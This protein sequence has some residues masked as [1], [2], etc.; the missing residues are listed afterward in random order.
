MTRLIAGS[1]AVAFVSWLWSVLFYVL[2]PI[3]YYTVSATR[4][5]LAA[6]AALLEHFPESGTYILPSRRSTPEVRATMRER[7]PVAT[8]YIKRDGAPMASP[9][10]VI[11]GTLQGVAIGFLLGLGM[12]WLTRKGWTYSEKLGV[13]AIF[14]L[15]YTLYPRIADILWSDFP[16]GY[17]WMMIF[18][19]GVSWLLMAAVMAWFTRPVASAA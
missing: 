12:R 17:Q 2:S 15:S 18:S 5:D 14:G 13:A 9:A 10:K 8:V 11:L 6:G 16:Q 4:D 19:D 3:P 1:L 7:G